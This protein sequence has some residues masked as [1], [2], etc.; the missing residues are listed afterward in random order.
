[1]AVGGFMHQKIINRPTFLK[2]ILQ[3]LTFLLKIIKINNPKMII[4]FRLK[5]FSIFP[6]FCV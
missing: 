2:M 5:S 4:S 6:I 3:K 1:M